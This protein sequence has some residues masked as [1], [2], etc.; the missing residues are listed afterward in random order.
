M[1]LKW[2]W[3]ELKCSVIFEKWQITW[4]QVEPRGEGPLPEGRK[5]CSSDGGWPRWAVRQRAWSREL[6]GHCGDG[7]DG[8]GRRRLWFGAWTSGFFGW[9][10][11]HP[12]RRPKRWE[13]KSRLEVAGGL[14]GSLFVDK[15][16]PF[17]SSQKTSENLP[18]FYFDLCSWQK[19][20]PRDVPQFIQKICNCC[21]II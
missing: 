11:H 2:T 14:G 9:V 7:R 21:C 13:E 10:S 5:W 18:M 19:D 1:L 15:M 4:L 12:E 6:L 3:F 17:L 20:I 16:V 8:R